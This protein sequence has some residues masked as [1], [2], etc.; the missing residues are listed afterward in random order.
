MVGPPPASAWQGPIC[1]PLGPRLEIYSLPDGPARP[2]STAPAPPRVGSK[3][4]GP[5]ATQRPA[6]TIVR[7]RAAAQTVR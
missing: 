3:R 4:G 5:R 7:L 1:G 6:A 2:S